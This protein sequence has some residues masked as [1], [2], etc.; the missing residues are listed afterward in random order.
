MADKVFKHATF[1][2]AVPHVTNRIWG[3]GSLWLDRGHAW[4]QLWLWHTFETTTSKG[5]K[6]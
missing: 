6:K 3:C 5:I 2:H 4:H 1:T